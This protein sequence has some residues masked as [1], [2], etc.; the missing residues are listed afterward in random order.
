MLDTTIISNF[1]EQQF[2]EIYREEGPFF[3]EFLRQYYIWMEV[4]SQSPVYQARRH[5]SNHDI[6]TTVDDFLLYFKEKYLKNIQLNTATNTKQ[7]IK[8]ALDLYRAKGSENAI[9]LFFD[10]IFSSDSEVYYPGNDVFRLSGAQWSIPYYL[11]VTPNAVN[12]LLVGRAITGINS[13]A[14]GFVEKLVRR[15]VKNYFVEILYI[16]AVTGDFSTGEIVKLANDDTIPLDLYPTITG[17]LTSV[18][19]LDG[20]DGFSK[21]EIVSLESKTGTDGRG[22]VMDLDTL[23][24]LVNFNLV[25]GG[26]GYTV[27]TN[28]YISEKVLSLSNVHIESTSNTSLAGDIV[29][30]YQPMANVQWYNNTDFFGVGDVVSNYYANGV[31]IGTSKIISAEYGTNTTTNFFLLN[32]LTGNNYMDPGAPYYYSSGN[33]ALFRV[34]NAGWVDE[35]A[36]GDVVGTG[37]V[38]LYCVGGSNSFNINDS[39]YQLSTNNQVYATGAVRSV[40]PTGANSFSL[41]IDNLDGLYL[42]NQPLLST[43]GASNVAITS[44]SYDMGLRLISGTFRTANGNVLFDTSSN[45]MW[46]ASVVRVSFG[47]GANTGIDSDLLYPETVSLNTNYVRDHLDDTVSTNWIN[48]TS[49]GASLN[50][51]NLTNKTLALAL[52]FQS[53]TVGKIARLKNQN[54]GEG[55]TYPPFVEINDPLV[56]PNHLLDFIITYEPPSGVFQLGEEVKQ[57]VS[58]AVGIVKAA[59]TT[60]VHIQRLTF[61][62]RWVAGNSANSYLVI[63]TSSGHRAFPTSVNYD[64]EG[65]AGGNALVTTNVTSSDSAVLDLKVVDSGF[66]FKDG[67]SV[68]FSSLD[69]TRSGSGRA[70]VVTMGHG[71]GFY[72]TTS[73]FLSSNKYLYDGNYYQ[74]FSYEIRSPVTV[75][76]Y[77]DMLKNVLH[78]AG[79]KFFSALVKSTNVEA[80]L[81][82]DSSNKHVGAIPGILT[83]P[84]ISGTTT[85]GSTLTSTTGTWTNSP[86]TFRYQWN[87]NGQ[88]I[89]G[90]TN[91]TY[92]VGAKDLGKSITCTVRAINPAGTGYATSNALNAQAQIIINTAAPVITGTPND[93]QTLT[94]SNAGTWAG[95][96]TAF[97][98]QWKRN[99]VNIDGAI[100][101]TYVLVDDDVD[102]II[103]CMVTASNSQASGS[104]DSNALGP[105]GALVPTNI[106]APTINGIA[107]EGNTLSIS[108]GTWTNSP[109]SFA[110]QWKRDG[111]DI[112]GAT[113]TTYVPTD[114]DIGTNITCTVTASNAAGSGSATTS[115]VGPVLSAAPANSTSPVVSGTGTSGQTLTTTNGTW[116]NLPTAYA[117]QWQSDG[118][119]I[120]GETASTHLLTVGD[121]GTTITCVVTASNIYGNASATSN[122]IGPIAAAGTAPTNTALPV[123]SGTTTQGQNLTTTNGTWTGSPTSYTY[124]WNR[125]A[126]PIT[127]ANGT[128]YTLVGADVGAN[129]T[130]DVTA[131][132]A[133]GST[134]ATSASVGPIASGAP[135]NTVAP[136]IT[137][138]TT[139]GQTLT[140]THGTW[141]NSPTG[142]TYQWNRDG[143]P[144]SSATAS[145]YTPVNADVGTTITCDVT[146]TNSFGNDTA[147]SNSVGPIASGA[148]PSNTV[149][150]AI[151]GTAKQGQTLSTTTGTWSGTPTLYA[152]QW[153]R[154]GVDISGAHGASYTLVAADVGANIT[155]AVTASNAFGGTTATSNSIGPIATATPVNSVLPAI[156][157]T[158]AQGQTL[159]TTNGTWTNS[160]TSFTYQWKRGGTN[161]SGAT[162]TTYVLTATDVGTTITCA[163]TATNSFGS[164]SATSAG[165]G[166]ITSSAPAN[167]AAPVISGT[168][169]QGQTLTTT[170]GSWTNSPTS[171]GYQW[172]RAGTNISGA[173][174]STYVL[175]SADIGNNIT[176][177][178]TATNTSGSASATSNSLGPVV[179]AVPSNTVAPSVSGS[180]TQGSTLTVSNGTWTN[181][182]TSYTYQ[183][184]RA[185]T[186]I[187]GATSGTYVLVSAD[188][189][190]NITCTV[191]A[192]NAFGS[193]SATSAAV[194]PITVAPP[195]NTTAPAISGTTA[196]GQ[197]LTTTNGSWTN[198]PTTYT[199]QWKRA[200]TAISGATSSTYVLVSADQGTNITCTVTATNAGGSASA[201]SAAV[202]PVTGSGLSAGSIAFDAT[203]G[204]TSGQNPP[205][206]KITL[207]SDGSIQVGDWFKFEY[208]SSSTFTTTTATAWHQI[209]ADDV[210]NSDDAGGW[211]YTWGSKIPAGLTYFRMYF[212][213]GATST[214]ITTTSGASNVI[215]D[216]LSAPVAVA[217]LD[218]TT[219]ARHGTN[220]TFT[221]NDRTIQGTIYGGNAWWIAGAIQTADTTKFQHGITYDLA[222]T[223]G[224]PG[225]AFGIYNDSTNFGTLNPTDGWPGRKDSNGVFISIT[226]NAGNVRIT[227]YMGAAP[228]NSASPDTN[229]TIPMATTNV[230]EMK[231]DISGAAGTHSYTIYVNGTAVLTRTGKTMTGFNRAFAGVCNNGKVTWNPGSTTFTHALDA[232]YAAY[233]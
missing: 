230:Y 135:S 17:S 121:V 217:K 206:I 165:V 24:G 144:I 157:G 223:G 174:G 118:V 76:R 128:T 82:M 52:T 99:G 130:C 34:Q 105:I 86:T 219:A 51:A 212:G 205:A 25:N 178:V 83:R 64:L 10:L 55:Y 226:N 196:V 161:I 20:G 211:I 231:V 133:F 100:S 39:A 85:V 122:G 182:P 202:G 61:E 151:S 80:K 132:N 179:S 54:P 138:T 81:S 193:A 69:N 232:G 67:D 6:D 146:A 112:A 23:T 215:N 19:V 74:D 153:K 109:T 124:Q 35:T 141:T 72:K 47:D 143:T 73:G 63:G 42:T 183:W 195:A 120:P 43:G 170:N 50:S 94:L 41:G 149:A 221:N 31:L 190:A 78:V 62:D 7:L 92:V 233:G 103:T 125:D 167:T 29:H 115:A 113:G 38:F 5:L 71:S 57:A 126:T 15:K 140:T 65:I 173:T 155:C 207:P 172:K 148:S 33:T 188:L 91:A 110:Y 114:P 160:P 84:T 150:P 136:A 119:D 213:R 93:G 26:W 145:T 200:G 185:G 197:T 131:V 186:N 98:Y 199:Y 21:G 222:A 154:G 147:T 70:S 96:P 164:T 123:L 107:K 218:K 210:I 77:S 53:K 203:S 60:A 27:N 59:N 40:A 90:A 8:N 87:R 58:G 194:G 228:V 204:W 180:T 159:T 177:T 156:S 66:S 88:S 166:P 106:S 198:S 227:D 28:I 48:A 117:Y 142:Y 13:G 224:S 11:E 176:C 36:E 37:N 175:V 4:D 32:K 45:S 102:T 220:L 162:A 9:K 56:Y 104:A 163:V 168:A 2:P 169:T 216:T 75:S 18:S 137:G 49:Y 44:A 14:T 184:K 46:S 22:L 16:S 129:I 30:I 139:E 1:I 209:T 134:T 116:T 229:T 158:T 214:T 89:I 208:S 187:S 111:A 189:G 225:G 192:S 108:N 181:S 79:T 95:S 191:T 3:V 12:R 68:T 97:A 152:Y 171:F 127:G 101:T 201:T